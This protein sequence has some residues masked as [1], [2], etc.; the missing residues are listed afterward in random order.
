MSSSHTER[1]QSARVDRPSVGNL[2]FDKAA[3]L[4][5]RIKR[6]FHRK[7]SKSAAAKEAK[8]W[9]DAFGFEPPP[10]PSSS[11]RPSRSSFRVSAKQLRRARTLPAII[12]PS[13]CIL[14]AQ[15]NPDSLRV[16]MPNSNCM[17]VVGDSPSCASIAST[18]SHHQQKQ[19]Q[20]QKQQVP[21]IFGQIDAK[22]NNCDHLSSSI[23]QP[24]LNSSSGKSLSLCHRRRRALF[25]VISLVT[26]TL[27]YCYAALSLS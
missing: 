12:T 8:E 19:Q 18:S 6:A 9:K 21:S 25:D 2:S 27:H 1:G 20:Q 5:L 26:V 3:V 4:I 7:K 15:I 10:A 11:Q 13:L 17:C 16:T 23:V 14:Q 24:T 22:L